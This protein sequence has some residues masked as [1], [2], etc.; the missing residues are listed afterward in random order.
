MEVLVIVLEMEMHCNGVEELERKMTMEGDKD[1]HQIRCSSPNDSQMI[2]DCKTPAASLLRYGRKSLAKYFEYYPL[3][4][5]ILNL[6]Q[7]LE[8]CHYK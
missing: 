3:R 7:I 8:I 4:F 1:S 2:H 6:I 5:R